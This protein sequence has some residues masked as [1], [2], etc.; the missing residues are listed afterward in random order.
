MSYTLLSPAERFPE[1]RTKFVMRS[2]YRIYPM[3]G[4]QH[5]DAPPVPGSSTGPSFGINQGTDR[6]GM[7]YALDKPPIGLQPVRG[8]QGAKFNPHH[9]SPFAK[10]DYTCKRPFWSW[11]CR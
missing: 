10:Y 11:K 9:V 3:P 8:L 7:A 4:P 6:P 5:Y 1:D 2:G